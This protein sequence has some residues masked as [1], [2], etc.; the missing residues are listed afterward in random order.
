LAEYEGRVDIDEQLLADLI[1]CTKKLEA[2]VGKLA[3][4]TAE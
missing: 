2:A 4:P 1:R 3:L